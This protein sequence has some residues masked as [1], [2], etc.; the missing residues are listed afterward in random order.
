MVRDPLVCGIH[1]DAIQKWLLAEPKLTYKRA[2]ELAQCL[3][4][5][6][7]NVEGMKSKKRC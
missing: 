6:A 4:T 7:Q 2:M 1:D 3:E 5:A